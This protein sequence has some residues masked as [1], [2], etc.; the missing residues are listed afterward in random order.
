MKSW[1]GLVTTA[2]I[3]SIIMFSGSLTESAEFDLS[4]SYQTAGRVKSVAISDNGEY[5]AAGSNDYSVYLFDREGNLLW[6]YD[7]SSEVNSVSVSFDGSYIAAG[8]GTEDSRV[9]LFDRIGQVLWSHHLGR[10]GVSS[11]SVSDDGSHVAGATG[12]PDNSIYYFYTDDRKALKTF[13]WSK[14][15]DEIINGLS[16][17]SDGRIVVAGSLDSNVYFFS[18][19]GELLDSHDIGDYAVKSVDISDDGSYVVVGDENNNVVLLEINS[20]INVIKTILNSRFLWSRQIEHDLASVSFLSNTS[21]IAVQGRDLNIVGQLVSTENVIYLYSKTGELLKTT[22][23]EEPIGLLSFS[24]DGSSIAAASE[25][26][27]DKLYYFLESASD[28]PAP[29]KPKIVVLANSIDLGLAQDFLDYL[30]DNG[31][32]VVHTPASDFDQYKSE[33]YIVILGGPD[34]PEGAGEI[35]QGVLTE[36][37]EDALREEGSSKIYLKPDVWEEGQTVWVIAGFNRNLT[38]TAHEDHRIAIVAGITSTS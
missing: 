4:W 12:N 28:P 33:N 15:I 19:D 31:L 27:H 26:I 32:E 34:A 30:M 24:E 17:S 3:L 2:L 35:A 6:D 13:L 1:P 8:T 11:V 25:Q 36:G 18:R 10:K 9:Y 22:R 14:S 29:S 5:L 16:A 7:A 20:N 37:E 23:I 21:D 38:R